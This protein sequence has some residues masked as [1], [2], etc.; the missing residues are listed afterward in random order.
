MRATKKIKRDRVEAVLQIMLDGAQPHEVRQ[1]VAEKTAAKE[2]PWTPTDGEKPLSERQLRRY[3]AE[4]DRLIAASCRTSRRML[5][6]RHLAQ[7]RALYARCINTADYSTALRVLRD[8]A[9]LRG[10]YPRPEDEMRREIDELKKTLERL[11]HGD[12][13]P[14]GGSQATPPADRAEA[15]SARTAA[16]P[17]A[18]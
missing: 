11:E 12:G 15:G 6:R 13:S 16:G 7:R 10:L 4:A 5:L 8:E 2:V 14:T 1:Y 17:A 3:M 9:E 18:S